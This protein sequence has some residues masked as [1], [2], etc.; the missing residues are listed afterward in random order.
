MN[1]SQVVIHDFSQSAEWRAGF[2][3]LAEK[4]FR[5]GLETNI[6][7]SNNGPYVSDRRRDEL[8]NISEFLNLCLTF[9]EGP[10]LLDVTSRNSW[11]ELLSQVDSV[12]CEADCGLAAQ[13]HVG[14]E[15]ITQLYFGAEGSL[16]PLP[17]ERFGLM[18]PGFALPL[19]STHIA[20]LKSVFWLPSDEAATE[21]LVEMVLEHECLQLFY[22]LPFT[23]PRYA[24]NSA[25]AESKMRCDWKLFERSF[26]EARMPIPIADAQR[27]IRYADLFVH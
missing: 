8:L 17:L 6:V 5:V 14:L 2:D 9:C 22:F 13:L 12:L 24:S 18:T 15:S 21:E 1:D 23:C 19:L 16:F 4:G 10:I 3:T 25:A 26:D 27:L 11:Q 20:S 7:Q